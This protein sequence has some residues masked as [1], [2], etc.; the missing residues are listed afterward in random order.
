MK[1][2]FIIL[3]ILVGMWSGVALGVGGE[4]TTPSHI[5][6]SAEVSQTIP[7]TSEVSQPAGPKKKPTE[8]S[9]EKEIEVSLKE[10]M[11]QLKKT[12]E[13]R[14][15]YQSVEKARDAFEEIT[16]K[17]AQYIVKEPKTEEER[18]KLAKEYNGVGVRLSNFLELE[19]NKSEFEKALLNTTKHVSDFAKLY[20]KE[21][22]DYIRLTSEAPDKPQRFVAIL[23]FSGV[24]ASVYDASAFELAFRKVERADDLSVIVFR[25]AGL[26]FY[27]LAEMHVSTRA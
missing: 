11:Q 17:I 24:H 5:P 6:G 7:G 18:V 21:L 15:G 10:K 19:K 14:V 3:F 16:Q 27:R 20:E 4:E 13:E 25:D 23:N 2:K 1:N 22:H 26:C 9:E 8:L 12:E